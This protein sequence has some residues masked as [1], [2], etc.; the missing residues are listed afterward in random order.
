MSFCAMEATSETPLR[1]QVMEDSRESTHATR[2]CDSKQNG[3]VGRG[4]FRPTLF[5][6]TR[7]DSLPYGDPTEP[8][9]TSP[10]K[11]WRGTSCC[12]DHKLKPRVN[13]NA[14]SH[15]TCRRIPCKIGRARQKLRHV[16]KSAHSQSCAFS[17]GL[18]RFNS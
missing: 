6:S 18:T 11:S 13:S 2:S 15:R 16:T 4:F 9:R 10:W 8:L 5:A 14:A 1:S 7:R 17:V 3:A 12:S